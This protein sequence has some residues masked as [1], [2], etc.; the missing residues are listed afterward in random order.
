MKKEI[1]QRLFPVEVARFY[2]GLCP[3]CAKPTRPEEFLDARSLKEYRISG[4]CEK[5]QDR[6]FE[7]V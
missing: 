1:M 2:A 6:V 7:D 4:L 3:S 5:C